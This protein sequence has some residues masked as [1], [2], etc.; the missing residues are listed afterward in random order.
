MHRA[1]K[2]KTFTENYHQLL[3]SKARTIKN[4]IMALH[5]FCIGYGKV[6]LGFGKEVDFA[7]GLSWHMEGLLPT[8]LTHY[9]VI[10][11][12]TETLHQSTDI[13]FTIFLISTEVYCFIS[14]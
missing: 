8:R 11:V 6:Y 1:R 3:H 9:L 13:H 10:D 4:C 12:R 14:I 5:W 7:K 2:L